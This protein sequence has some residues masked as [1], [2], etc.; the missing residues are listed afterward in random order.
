MG[1]SGSLE[2]VHAVKHCQGERRFR[3]PESPGPLSD[4]VL[5]LLFMASTGRRRAVDWPRSPGCGETPLKDRA[6]RFADGASLRHSVRRDRGRAMRRHRMV[7]EPRQD[8][9][10]PGDLHRRTAGIPA[11]RDCDSMTGS[12]HSLARS[13]TPRR[14]SHR[15]SVRRQSLRQTNAA[16]IPCSTSFSRTGISARETAR[17]AERATA[18]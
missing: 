16:R 8:P 18:L 15:P 13:R 6:P 4:G 5:A 2:F 1:V 3:H 7:P 17:I 11:A 9:S 12:P 14:R 10:V